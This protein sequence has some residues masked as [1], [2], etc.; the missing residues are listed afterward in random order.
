MRT[1]RQG[2]QNMKVFLAGRGLQA[3]GAC[4]IIEAQHLCIYK[5]YPIIL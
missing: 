2:K 3:K 5:E 4:V 1:L